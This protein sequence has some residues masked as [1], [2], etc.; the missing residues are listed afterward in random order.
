M[1]VTNEKL[2][3]TKET[4]KEVLEEFD[5]TTG[6]LYLQAFLDVIASEKYTTKEEMVMRLSQIVYDNL[7]RF[8]ESKTSAVRR[9]VELYNAMNGR[10]FKP[11]KK[12]VAGMADTLVD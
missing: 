7:K 5:P 9:G 8:S 12:V 3:S 1:S 4:A 6:E 11:T 2:L 10:R